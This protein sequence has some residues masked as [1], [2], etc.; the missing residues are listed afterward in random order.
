MENKSTAALAA[1]QRALTQIDAFGR[2]NRLVEMEQVCRQLLAEFPDCADGWNRLGIIMAER[3]NGLQALA[4]MERAIRIAPAEPSFHA[5]LGEMMRRAGLPDKALDYC[6]RAI[7]LDQSHLVARLNLA[8]ALLDLGRAADSVTHFEYVVGQEG[9]NTKAWFGLG[10]AQ[11]TLL[12]FEAAISSMSRCVSL[13]PNDALAW[14]LL[15]RVRL[16]IDDVDRALQDTLRA[17][18]LQPG[19]LETIAAYTDALLVSGRIVDAEREL[20]NV[21]NSIPDNAQLQYRLALCRLDQRDYIE[22]FALYE[23]RLRMGSSIHIQHPVVS[24]PMWTNEDIKGRR[25]LVIT[26]QGYG[27]HIQFYRFIDQLIARGAEVVLS[28]SPPMSDLMLTQSGSLPILTRIEDTRTSGCDYWTFIGSLPHRLNIKAADVT[29]PSPYLIANPSKRAVWR[30]QLARYSPNRLVG[31]VWAGRPEHQND[32]QRSIQ[33]S[34]LAKLAEAKGVTFISLQTGPRSVDAINQ[35]N[36][37]QVES[38]VE[39][40]VSFDDTAALIA[41][42]DLVISVDSAPAHLAGALGCPVWTLLPRVADWRW[43]LA[44]DTSPWYPSMRLF[45]QQSRGN[46]DD[47]VQSV[48]SSLNAFNV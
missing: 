12:Q 3:N 42:L 31:L 22:G 34:K 10:R 16:S 46:W 30:E 36:V 32:R 9:G 13:A 2:D 4:C 23:S 18:K 45:R 19:L 15:A 24:M 33:F 21:L 37:F 8:Y 7:N 1:I 40:L 43:S 28:V 27:D 38:F 29:P 39:K 17:I 11:F 26:E 5:N 6:T 41:E 35:R 47:V 44:R 48:L 25:L 14:V 20:R